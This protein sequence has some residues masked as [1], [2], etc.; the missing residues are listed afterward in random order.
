MPKTDAGVIVLAGDIHIGEKG[1][2][3]VMENIPARPVIYVLGNHEYYGN[4][5]LRLLHKLKEKTK[6]TNIYILENEATEIEDVTF[7]GC[8]LWTD[9]E[10]FGNPRSAEY[11]ASQEMMD[12]RKIRRSPGYSKLKPSDVAVV[13]KKSAFWLKEAVSNIQT[14]RVVCVTHHAPSHRSITEQYKNN[15]LSA[16]YASNLDSLV[17]ESK[18]TL[19]IHGHTHVSFDYPIG[20]T[21]IVCNPR[22]YPDERNPSFN[23]GFIAQI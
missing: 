9:F 11:R 8:T 10:L 3:W 12:F 14:D 17:I 22:G 2:L 6:G 16:A 4:A 20:S 23:P 21:R 15:L 1:I 5:Y 18:A 7:L 19:W 13:H